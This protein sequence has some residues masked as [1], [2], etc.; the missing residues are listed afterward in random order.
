MTGRHGKVRAYNVDVSGGVYGNIGKLHFTLAPV[1]TYAENRDFF[2]PAQDFTG[3]RIEKSDFSFPFEGAIDWVVR[4]GDQAFYNFHPG[5]SEVRFI[6]KNFTVGLSTTNVS[7][8]PSRYNPILLS[9][10]AGGFPRLDIGTFRP[11]K[12]KIGDVEFR[13]MWGAFGES[14]YFD[15]DSNN[16]R[17]YFT[18]FT[19]GYRPN[20]IEGLN[21]GLNRVMY[22]RWGEGDLKFKDFFASLTQNSGTTPGQQNDIYDQIASIT[23]DW[24]FPSIGFQAYVEYARN[25]FPGSFFEFMEQPDRSRARTIGMIKDIDLKNGDLLQIIYESTV[26]G[27]N[28]VQL[29]TGAGGG[30]PTYY[31]HNS[32]ILIN[33]YTNNGQILGAGIG[34][35]SQSDILKLHWYKRSGRYGFHFSR[36]RL[37]DDYFVNAYAGTQLFEP[38]PTDYEVT[39]GLDWV[40]FVGD[41]SIHPEILYSHRRNFLYQD[42]E[43]IDNV[44]FSLKTTYLLR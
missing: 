34:P 13:V 11:T 41:F 15:Q 7:I 31:V 4:Y 8:G 27:A 23:I 9:K 22:A 14:A 25:D 42:E 16:D 44:Y 32:A 1:F 39:V 17:R 33:G 5:Q 18:G 2:I 36:I 12:T 40:K 26:L 30:N 37:D 28:Q 21:I 3:R 24:H 43:E 29:V 38:Y 10:N 35:G 19:F 20:F 6:S